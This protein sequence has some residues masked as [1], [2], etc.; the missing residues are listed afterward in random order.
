MP[1]DNSTKIKLLIGLCLL[2]T[3]VSLAIISLNIYAPSI[4]PEKVR[5]LTLKE[6]KNILFLGVD[7]VFKEDRAKKREGGIWRGRSDT[8]IILS[9]DPYNKSMNILNIPRDTRIKIDGYEIEKINY[10]NAIDGPIVTKKHVEKLLGI[11]IHNYVQINLKGAVKFIDEIGGIVINVPQRMKYKDITG[12]VDINLFPGRQL[13]N[14]KQAIDFVRFRHDS[15]GD[16]GRIQRQQEFIRALIKKSLDP[17]VFARLPA[18]LVGMKHLLLTDLKTDGIVRI[19]NFVRN[20]PASKQKI[21]M[22]PGKFGE[23]NGISY[24]IPTKKETIEIVNEFFKTT[25]T[26]DYKTKS[27]EPKAQSQNMDIQ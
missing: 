8:I 2:I 5:V 4:L 25:K 17:V 10:L 1:F 21:A 14:G 11:K 15:L 6:R 18:L 24:W 16:I 22:L 7:E 20:V 3:G 13:L 12:M 23:L 19:A 9:L 27:Q 26:T